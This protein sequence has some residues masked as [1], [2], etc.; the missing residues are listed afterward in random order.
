MLDGI[1]RIPELVSHTKELGMH[2]LAITDHGSLYGAVEFYSECKEAG[3]KPI[4]GCEVYVA[5]SSRREKSSSERSPH[6][7]VLLA[8][9]NVG[10]QNLMQLVT[11]GHLEGFHYRPRID[12]EL[13]VEMGQGLI[14]L[15]GCPSAEVPKLIADGNI[16]GA[17]EAAIWYQELFKD[18]YFLE[19]QSHQQVPQLDEINQGLVKLS[20]ELSIPLIVTNDSHYVELCV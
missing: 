12:K 20:K 3:I 5:H 17:K 6:H 4:I 2:S 7:L 10:Y 1:S 8:R 18:G 11:L 15:S 14:C 16:E 19:L 13:L 9:N